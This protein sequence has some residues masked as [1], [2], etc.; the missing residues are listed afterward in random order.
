MAH[1]DK[2]GAISVTGASWTEGSLKL[3][4]SGAFATYTFLE[5][6]EFEVQSGTNATT[7][8][9]R[10]VARLD[11]NSITLERS[12]GSSASAVMGQMKL[13]G[14]ALPTDFAEIIGMHP[15]QG[16]IAEIRPIGHE[17]LLRLRTMSAVTV[18]P[19]HVFACV[20]GDVLT[21]GG[22]AP[23]PRMEI[24]PYPTTNDQ[25]AFLL[26]YRKKW[27][28]PTG[29]TDAIAIPDW[30][31]PLFIATI[32]ATARGWEEEDTASVSKRLAEVKMSTQFMDASYYD[33]AMQPSQGMIEGGAAARYWGT[34]FRWHRTDVLV[35]VP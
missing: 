10:I 4:A 16:I 6:D 35:N 33:G 12:I 34:N 26:F 23:T 20:Y 21:T 24:Y 32:R 8:F 5:G 31:E 15:K 18:S 1:L 27:T 3:T 9:Y 2:R 11:A 17:E 22:G 28:T 29:D 7:G 14:I 13:G 30:M 19:F 25:G